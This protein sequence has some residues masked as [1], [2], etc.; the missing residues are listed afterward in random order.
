MKQRV[1]IVCI[2]VILLLAVSGGCKQSDKA[3]DSRL[4]IVCT[5]FPQYDWVRQI[6]GSKTDGIAVSLLM[7]GKADLHNY[8]PT[9]DDIVKISACDL[10]IYVGGESDAWA[11]TV[12]KQAAN[13]NM[14]TINLLRTLGEKAKLEEDPLHEAAGVHHHEDEEDEA[15]YDEHVWLSLKNAEVFCAAIADTLAALDAD[16]AAYY[17][18]NLDIYIKKL[19]ELH[20]EYLAITRTAPVKTLLFGDRFPFRYL[21][22]EYNLRAYAAFP[23]CSAE[24]EASFETIALLAKKTDELHLNVVIVTESADTS[25]A[26]TIIGNTK[27]KNQ[28]ILVLD[29]MQSVTPQD[30][31]NG[32]TYLSIMENNLTVLQEALR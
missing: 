11:G 30:V 13:T 22:D 24:T 9:A 3:S 15:E 31:K 7:S 8:Q 5:V 1:T 21:A 16:N 19:S 10:F 26:K 20:A 17:K 14:V 2:S 23:G 6:L 12:L 29:S 27:N 28:K 4:S 18:S 32:T 25:I